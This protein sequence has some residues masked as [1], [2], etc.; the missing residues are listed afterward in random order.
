MTEAELTKFCEELKELSE[1]ELADM[2]ELRV[3]MP[4][5]EADAGPGD[6]VDALA[7]ARRVMDRLEVSLTQMMRLHAGLRSVLDAVRHSSEDAEMDAVRTTRH[8]EFV[9]ARERMLTLRM[10]TLDEVRKVRLVEKTE[11]LIFSRLETAR[12]V[13][14]GAENDRRD[15][16]T[17][18][19]ALTLV[20]QM[21]RG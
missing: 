17:R 2:R 12:I 11:R 16:D 14:R 6:L 7:L 21:E 9:S 3:E 8:G 15:L 10:A 13:Y 4:A 1:R 20:T 18:L 19:R 5:L